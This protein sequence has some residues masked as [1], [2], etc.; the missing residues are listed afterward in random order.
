MEWTSNSMFSQIPPEA[1]CLRHALI[2]YSAV[3]QEGAINIG[4]IFFPIEK[5]TWIKPQTT[6][7]CNSL[8]KHII[9]HI[10]SHASNNLGVAICGASRVT[11]VDRAKGL[12]KK[13]RE[14]FWK[15][16][17]FQTEVQR[18]DSAGTGRLCTNWKDNWSRCA[19]LSRVAQRGGLVWQC[20]A[21]HREAGPTTPAGLA[22]RPRCPRIS[23]AGPI[24][25]VDE[26]DQREGFP[27]Q[28]LLWKQPFG[29][30]GRWEIW[31]L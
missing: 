22:F 12:K 21:L 10:K 2:H 19:V 4:N 27:G 26:N 3:Y 20:E 14:I 11:L 18:G 16:S 30:E 17:N 1:V 29:I 8:M 5:K 31:N 7:Q 13:W 9:W 23:T 6:C 28:D 15:R 25:S 24:G